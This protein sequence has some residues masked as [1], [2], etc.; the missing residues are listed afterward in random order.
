MFRV[1]LLVA[2]VAGAFPQSASA[3]CV[4]LSVR[5]VAKYAD[6][7]FSGTV[8]SIDSDAV[9]FDVDRVWKGP[10]TKPFTVYIIRSIDSFEP[11]LGVKYLVSALRASE[12]ERRGFGSSD[13]R[14]FVL[15]QCGSGTRPWDAVSSSEVKELGRGRSPASP[16]GHYPRRLLQRVRL[17]VA[18]GGT[19]CKCDPFAIPSTSHWTGAAIIVRV[20]RTKTYIVTRWKTSTGPMPSF[21][22][23]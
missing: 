4:L 10:V 7:I 16:A 8:T 1:A 6:A 2:I 3:E 19:L 20:L 18:T 15:R 9:T 12:D 13:R 17:T 21:S 22:A 5:T 23:G 14:V 11:R